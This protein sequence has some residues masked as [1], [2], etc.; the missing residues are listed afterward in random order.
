MWDKIYVNT[1]FDRP[2]ASQLGSKGGQDLRTLKSGAHVIFMFDI[3]SY[4]IIIVRTQSEKP[5]K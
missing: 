5:I 4:K 2:L 3:N 1:I